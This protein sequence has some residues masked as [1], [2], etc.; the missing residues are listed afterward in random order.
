VPMELPGRSRGLRSGLLAGLLA[1]LLLAG[2]TGIG[3]VHQAPPA[4]RTLDQVP[5]FPQTEWQCGPAALATVLVHSGVATTPDQLADNIY[6]P[7]RR[8]SLQLEL[9]AAARHSGRMPWVIPPQPEALWAELAAGTPVLV[10]QDL[11]ALGVRRWHYAVVVGF[12]ARRERVILRSGTERERSEPLGRFLR[13]WARSEYWA[14]VVSEPGELPVTVEAGGWSRMLLDAAEVMPAALIAESWDAALARWPDDFLVG[15]AAADHA[16][17]HGELELA[18]QRYRQLLTRAEQEPLL[19][20]NLANVLL[21]QGC[22]AAALQEARRA[23]ALVDP[24]SP[25]RAALA[26]TLERALRAA[27]GP[28]T[29]A[30]ASQADASSIGS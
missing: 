8:G 22:P 15:F 9:I 21:D 7:G 25:Y 6:L 1:A 3:A 23:V 27:D 19:R 14:L 18:E 29:G 11:G 12:D 24:E 2:C 13:S 10:L 16:H 5:F 30:C 4:V 17:R 26:A 28:G 20:N